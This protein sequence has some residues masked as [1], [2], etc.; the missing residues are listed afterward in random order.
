MAIT[1]QSS[2][3]FFRVLKTSILRHLMELN[4]HSDKGRSKFP[5]LLFVIYFQALEINNWN[6]RSE[7]VRITILGREVF[8]TIELVSISLLAILYFRQE[9]W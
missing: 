6:R 4:G 9:T 3:W 1:S 2:S 8:C 5:H 7:N